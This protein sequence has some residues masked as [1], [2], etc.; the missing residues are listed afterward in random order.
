MSPREDKWG[1]PGRPFSKS[2]FGQLPHPATIPGSR[3]NDKETKQLSLSQASFDLIT[4]MRAAIESASADDIRRNVELAEYSTWRDDSL[5]MDHEGDYRAYFAPFDWINDAADIVIVGVTPGKQ[6]ALDALLTLRTALKSGHPVEEA[7]RQSKNAASFKGGMRTLGARLMD[8]FR[9]HELFK[10]N[11]TL[12]LFGKSA[13]R[14]HYTSALRYPVMKNYGNYAGD[15]RIVKRDFMRRM[16]ETHLAEELAA[17]PN[18]WIVPFGPTALLALEHLVARGLFHSD[19]ILGGI[20][21]PGGQQWNRYNVQLD[22]VGR[23][24]AMAVPGGPAL[25][26][27]GATL[28]ARVASLLDAPHL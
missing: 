23:E 24:A 14:A 8:H 1:S 10:M 9:F 17:L 16:I 27:S 4:R 22:L 7:A 19:R 12:D 26:Q 11:S 20:L 18:A 3:I 25:L 6:Q 15:K 5:G 21:H 13:G 28:R 2:T